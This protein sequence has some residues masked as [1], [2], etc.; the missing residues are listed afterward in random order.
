MAGVR[1]DIDGV[2][3]SISSNRDEISDSSDNVSSANISM[4]QKVF[5]IPL[6]FELV[7]LPNF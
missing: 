3:H 6:F 4:L 5:K 1:H 7:L 2:R